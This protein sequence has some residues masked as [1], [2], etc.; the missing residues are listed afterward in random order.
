[1]KYGPLGFPIVPHKYGELDHNLD[2][3]PFRDNFSPPSVLGL[4]LSDHKKLGCPMEIVENFEIE[5]VNLD[6][7]VFQVH[8]DGDYPSGVWRV[9]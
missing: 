5:I 1:M 2:V 6:C 7:I 8:H 3:G 4:F 9:P